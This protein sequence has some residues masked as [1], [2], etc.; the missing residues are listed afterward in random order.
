MAHDIGAF[1]AT[2]PSPLAGYENAPALPDEKNEDG[3]SYVNP[4]R[5]GL[6]D[7]YE[8]FTAPLNNG[9]RGGLYV[10]ILETV[11]ARTER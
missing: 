9:T 10:I 11:N 4:P 3:K 5:E 1:Q 8:K 2:W 6:S 7:S